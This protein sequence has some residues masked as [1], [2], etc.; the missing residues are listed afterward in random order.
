[1]KGRIRNNE[2]NL[3]LNLKKNKNNKSLKTGFEAAK[4]I[5][6]YKEMKFTDFEIFY[7]S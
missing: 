5:N 3:H 4:E 2:L 7:Y 1:M 6:K